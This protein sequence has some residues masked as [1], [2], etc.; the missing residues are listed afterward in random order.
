MGEDIGSRIG[1]GLTEN[2]CRKNTMSALVYDI[3]LHDGRDTNHYLRQ[4]CRV[5]AVDANP[6][7][8]AA[9][10]ANFRDCVRTGQLTVI[11]RGVAEQKDQ[12]EFW[13]C[14]DVSEWS[15]FHREIASR[16][17]AKHHAIGVDCVPIGDI[18]DEFGVPDYMKIDIEGNDRI[19][20]S[21]LTSATAPRYISIEM[22]H[23]CGDRDLQI[24]TRL[25]YRR[26]KLICQNN[27]WHQVT[28]WNI[29]FYRWQPDH[30]I[31]RRL[32]KLRA[33]P[34]K[35]LAGRKFGESGP[36]GEKTSGAWHSVDHAYSVWRSLQ[37]LDERQ[38]THGLGWWF[39]IHAK[40]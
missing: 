28:T 22:D 20:I 16:N 30:F 40:K 25:G 24:L 13:V 38:G 3:G 39:D 8:C 35:L 37:K 6:V 26:F 15:S 33:V 34:P 21:G 29:S 19:C 11:N 5:V 36:W 18:I 9:A 27:S 17:G 2:Q 14:D 4:G 32:R 23:S 7:M 12:L 10:E 1:N 31:I